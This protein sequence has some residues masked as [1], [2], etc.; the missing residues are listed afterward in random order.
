MLKAIV[1][2]EQKLKT[3]SVKVK[4]RDILKSIGAG[5]PRINW[6]NAVVQSKEA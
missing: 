4:I 6:L 3:F 5:Y 1:N 2:T